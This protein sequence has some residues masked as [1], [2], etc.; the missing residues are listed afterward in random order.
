MSQRPKFWIHRSG[1]FWGGFAIFL[2]LFGAWILCMFSY[3]E[4]VHLKLHGS[5]MRSASLK[6]DDGGIDG[7]WAIQTYAPASGRS[8]PSRSEWKFVLTQSKGAILKPELSRDR[9]SWGHSTLERYRFFLPLWLPLLAWTL[10]WIYRMYRQDKREEAL[11]G[12][13]AEL[14]VED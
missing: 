2:F 9:Q 14:P 4:V 12:Q 11:F 5:S 13:V 1:R 10:Y 6:L 8:F 3:A 7:V